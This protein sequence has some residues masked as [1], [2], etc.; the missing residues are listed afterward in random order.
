MLP[1][2]APLAGRVEEQVFASDVLRDNSVTRRVL[3]NVATLAGPERL[4][5]R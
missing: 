2:S 3:F 1:W 5:A 4:A